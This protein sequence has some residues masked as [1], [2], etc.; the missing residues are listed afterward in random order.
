MT[1]PPTQPP[2]PPAGPPVTPQPTGPPPATYG[3]PP[4]GGPPYSEWWKRVVAA[5]IDGLIITIPGSILLALLGLGTFAGAEITCDPNTGVCTTDAG[6]GVFIGFLVSMLVY[7]AIAI[8]YQVYF[9]GGEKGQTVGKMAMK[10]RVRDDATGGPIGYGK[11]FLRWLVG[12]ALGIFTCGI[13]L[14]IDLLFPLWDPKRQTL[15]DKAANSVVI[16]VE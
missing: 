7:A 9:N 13:G 1:Q 6:P 11:A 16:D 8:G 10:I 14:L 3:G 5:I 2:P 15:H 12:W 4:P